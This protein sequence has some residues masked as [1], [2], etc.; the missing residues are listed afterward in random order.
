MSW[1]SQKQNMEETNIVNIISRGPNIPYFSV[2]I[3]N[4]K[5]KKKKIKKIK[6]HREP[7]IFHKI[8]MFLLESN[9]FLC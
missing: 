4:T 2:T 6:W 9:Y 7:L 1:D 8:V 5:C 3:Q